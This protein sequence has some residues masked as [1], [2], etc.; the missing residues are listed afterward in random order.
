MSRKI[1]THGNP[2]HLG[3]NSFVI[4]TVESFFANCKGCLY[5]QRVLIVDRG[6]GKMFINVVHG[7]YDGGDAGCSSGKKECCVL[8]YL[9]M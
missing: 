8:E 1:H 5:C 7:W 4:V 3:V 9:T 6:C 2:K